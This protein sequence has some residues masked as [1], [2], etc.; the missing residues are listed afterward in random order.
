M[1]NAYAERAIRLWSNPQGA[2]KSAI[3]GGENTKVGMEGGKTVVTYPVPGVPGAIA[4][5]TLT[6]GPIEGVCTRNCAERVEVR[7]GDVVTEFIYSNYADYNAAE[8]QLDAFY[9]GRII[10]RRGGAMVLDITV[11]RTNTPNQYIV[12]PVPPAVRSAGPG[13]R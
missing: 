13:A 11:T 9:A 12:V 4:R 1:P 5:A 8:E 7:Q 10:E 3:M 6:S 2:V